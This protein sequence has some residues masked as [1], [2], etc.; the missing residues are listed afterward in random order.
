MKK[1]IRIVVIVLLVILCANYAG[2]LI[3][4][5]IETSHEIAPDDSQLKQIQQK[6]PNSSSVSK[7][8]FYVF[9]DS[10][11]RFE[12]LDKIASD[13]KREHPA[14]L[15][16]VGDIVSDGGLKEFEKYYRWASKLT[17]PSFT[18]LGN[19][20]LI[21]KTK[22]SKNYSFFFGPTYYSFH[23]GNSYFIVLDDA[24]SY[25]SDKQLD[26]LRKTLKKAKHYR[27]IFVFAHQP[28]IDPRKGMYHC[29]KPIWSNRSELIAILKRADIDIFFASHIHSYFEYNI[30][31]IR[32]IITGG[33]GA[34]L[35]PPMR[36]NHYVKVV[37]DKD[38]VYTQLKL[39]TPETMKSKLRDN[40]TKEELKNDAQRTGRHQG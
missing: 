39:I 36:K 5:H 30:D 26:W 33:A 29:M 10:K 4:Q 19:H 20:D 40:I 7:F 16:N 21:R 27:H 32:C 9:G 8:S 17:V 38:N 35:K 34:P 18:V 22:S 3:A 12:V 23:Y 37:V 25:I 1:I 13:A 2:K 14:F 31:G 11:G 6:L 15:I 28:I 24:L